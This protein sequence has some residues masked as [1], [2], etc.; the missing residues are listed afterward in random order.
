MIEKRIEELGYKLPGTRQ[1]AFSFDSVV[2]HNDVAYISGTLPFIDG[3]LKTT[4]K[5]GDTV[6][7]EEA[8]ELARVCILNGLAALKA[9]IGSLENVE[10]FLKVT[11]FV[12]SATGFFS[13]AKVM[14]GASKILIDIFE[15]RGRHARSAV[16][17]AV[18]PRNTPVEIEMIVAIKKS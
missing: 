4:G 11:G 2:V 1:S 6:T 10:R 15:E 3:E 18:M 17:A 12:S 16:G 7:I 5:V 14:E 13:Q 8:Q 9:E